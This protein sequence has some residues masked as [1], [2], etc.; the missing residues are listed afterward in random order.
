MKR[1]PVSRQTDPPELRE[2][3]TSEKLEF[4]VD[5]DFLSLPPRLDPQVML[6][7]LEETMPKGAATAANVRVRCVVAR[8][9]RVAVP[10]IHDGR[11]REGGGA[12][13]Q[14]GRR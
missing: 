5:P 11:V 1:Y 7:R 8:R 10:G 9:Q 2:T 13:R 12:V 6:R 4:P 3:A 14:G